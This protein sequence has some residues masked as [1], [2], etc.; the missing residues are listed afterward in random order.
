MGKPLVLNRSCRHFFR[1]LLGSVLIIV[2]I[3]ILIIS[4]FCLTDIDYSLR[5]LKNSEGRIS[6]QEGFHG[7]N[8]AELLIN[9]EGSYSRIY[10]NLEQPLPLEDLDRLSLWVNPQSGS[11]SIQFDIYL[12]GDGDGGYSSATLSQD[13]RI[14][15]LE[16]DWSDLQISNGQ[17]NELDGF[18]LDYEIYRGQS[19]ILY[20]L[21]GLQEELRG[22]R[23]V[24]IYITVMGEDQSASP[25]SP[26]T[27]FIDYVKIGDEVISFEP[28]EEEDIKDGPSS[29][30][31]GGLMTYTITYGNNNLQ[32]TDVIVKE[33]YDPRT[34][35]IESTPSPDAGSFDTWTFSSLPAGAHGQI[36]IKMRTKKPSATA[37]IDGRVSGRGLTAARGLLSTEFDGYPVT[38]NV[39]VQA[40]EFNYTASATTRIKPIVG[41]TLQYSEHGSG[42]YRSEEELTY[43]SASIAA[44]RD[45]LAAASPVE[46]DLSPALAAHNS[47]RGRVIA[48][49]DWC[50]AIRAENDYRD[51]LWSDRY[52]QAKSLNLSYNARLGKTLSALKTTVQVTG[53]ADR[54]ALWPEGL[55]ETRLAGNFSL[56]GSARWKYSSRSISAPKLGLECCPVVQGEEVS[57]STVY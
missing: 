37:D 13:A 41:S 36:V 10:V 52:W 16:R 54:E 42:E 43:G 5:K 6:E 24:K 50:A 19:G 46:I 45:V 38:N 18:D 21:D 33:D 22:K 47:S 2:I 27:V 53:L 32:P 26:T 7:S 8:S 44:N 12:D 55:A 15:S 57:E 20:S 34:V 9:S 1:N 49:V 56:A 29:A 11:A 3:Q 39:V 17:W 30:T 14:L 48:R 28:L 31:P 4:S 40:G 35:F 51:I 25:S 23:V